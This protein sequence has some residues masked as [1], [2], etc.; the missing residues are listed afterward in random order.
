MD[1]EL[2][3]FLGKGKTGI[4]AKYHR[5]DKVICSHSREGKTLSYSKINTVQNQMPSVFWSL[6]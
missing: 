5:T 4:I 2:W 6:S 3:D 1:L